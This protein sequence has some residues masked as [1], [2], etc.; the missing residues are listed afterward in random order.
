MD[1]LRIFIETSLFHDAEFIMDKNPRDCFRRLA[2]PSSR[3]D[4]EREFVDV[5]RRH[6]FILSDDT[7]RL[8]Y[9]SW[10]DI[11]GV[12]PEK[13]G[14]PTI[15]NSLVWAARQFLR[16]HKASPCVDFRELFRWR[17]FTRF[18]GEDIYVCAYL[19]WLDRDCYD[20]EP[21]LFDDVTLA[22][23]PG[24]PND[25]L[26]I[27]HIRSKGMLG[28]LH[29]HLGASAKVLDINWISLMNNPSGR[30]ASFRRLVGSHDFENRSSTGASLCDVVANAAAIRFYLYRMLDDA[31][32]QDAVRKEIDSFCDL[33]FQ[34]R[35]GSL[36]DTVSAYKGL[37][38]TSSVRLRFDYIAVRNAAPSDRGSFAVYTGERRFLYLAIRHALRSGDMEFQ[39]WLLYYILAKNL[40][41]KYMVQLNSNH[42]FSNFQRYQDT[43][44]L[45]LKKRYSMLPSVLAVPDAC[46]DS[47]VAFQEVRIAP[48]E[49][50]KV[51]AA[52]L[53][54]I[55]KGIDAELALMEN[56]GFPKP[57][58]SFIYHFIKKPE[59]TRSQDIVGITATD[60]RNHN[61]R[62]GLKVQSRNIRRLA[63]DPRNGIVGIDAASSEFN[64]RPEVFGQ[65]FRY[66]RH[67][68]L[69]A[70]FHAGEDF[71]DLADGIRAI[72]EAITF[73]RL[74]SGD[75]L[76]HALAMGIES[77]EYYTSRN[78][79]IP[80]PAQWLLDNIVWLY[81]RG[82]SWNVDIRPD[83][84]RYLLKQ[85]RMLFNEIYV[86]GGCGSASYDTDIE[87]YHMSML[88]RGNNPCLY[89]P[90]HFDGDSAPLPHVRNEWEHYA[91]NDTEIVRIATSN[92]V[93]VEIYRNYHFNGDV[94][95]RGE[96]VKEFHI[97]AG[98]ASLITMMQEKMMDR[99]ERHGLCVECCPSSNLLIGSLGR[100]DRH[101]IFRFHD[102]DPSKGHHLPVTINTDD[103][104]VFQTSLANE[105]SYLALAQFKSKRPDGTSVHSSYEVSE[106]LKRISA[107]AEK[108]R[109]NQGD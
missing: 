70:T 15:L 49:D 4:S 8:I 14:D 87:T 96:R 84:E 62:H 10:K 66:L 68:G 43:K 11:W 57:D 36:A 76:G 56:A 59:K 26:D 6:V 91:F 32:G 64:C 23:P 55:R 9:R 83:I 28:D 63:F 42:G 5:A 20:S 82:K 34:D 81:C 75:R 65:A 58:Y 86:E 60:E 102:I 97:C 1:H 71:Y 3:K 30:S 51:M 94:R 89:K 48:H 104:G 108:Y 88:L 33:I 24:L 21:S 25:N 53:R 85:F 78:N 74:A 19:A 106:W 80:I 31:I 54:A 2:Y 44:S 45:F 46:R 72:D 7:L 38:S 12:D 73:L 79:R 95:S 41:R 52:S 29:C 90:N 67:F 40:V 18:L 50:F 39:G 103:L 101:P 109:F 17:D 69:K 107:C 77:E 22:F 100:F 16:I 99:V 37:D 98:Y 47:R 13:K 27:R 61:V 105:Y 93:A 92:P 35:Y